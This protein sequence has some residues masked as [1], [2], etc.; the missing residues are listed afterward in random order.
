MHKDV[1]FVL[2]DIGVA[3]AVSPN[4][5]IVIGPKNAITPSN[6]RSIRLLLL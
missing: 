6:F 1:L 3:L 4:M 2:F 5:H